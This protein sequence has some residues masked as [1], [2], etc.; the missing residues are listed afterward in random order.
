MVVGRAPGS[1][2]RIDNEEIQPQHLRV[3]VVGDSFR[4]ETLN[5][6]ASFKYRDSL[7]TSGTLPPTTLTVGRFRVRLSHQRYP[8]LIVFDPTSPR[9][10][11]Y[12]GLAYYPVDFAY[13]FEL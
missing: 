8:A 2:V 12:K 6:A 5:P 7:M 3:A 9:F 1:D 11:E 4:V 13:R 10:T